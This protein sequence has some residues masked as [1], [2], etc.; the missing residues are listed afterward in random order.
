MFSL[1]CSSPSSHVE[2][3]W[4]SS[5]GRPRLD[6]KGLKWEAEKQENDKQETKW[7]GQEDNEKSRVE[8]ELDP[9]V[10]GKTISTTITWIIIYRYINESPEGSND[11]THS[12]IILL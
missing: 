3:E 8:M 2:L 9:E 5:F 11:H 10:I 6:I 4:L 12:F 1:L 7:K